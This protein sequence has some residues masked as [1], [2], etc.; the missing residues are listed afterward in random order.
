M[1]QK[2]PLA[3]GE[4]GATG[5]CRLG[6]VLYQTALRPHSWHSIIP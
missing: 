4:G 1:E 6:E 2:K 3:S 5:V